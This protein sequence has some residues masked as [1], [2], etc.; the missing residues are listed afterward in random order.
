M[1]LKCN[2]TN[3]ALAKDL[4]RLRVIDNCDKR[5]VELFEYNSYKL[6]LF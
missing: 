6:S 1:G 3:Q 5:G 4:D 2:R